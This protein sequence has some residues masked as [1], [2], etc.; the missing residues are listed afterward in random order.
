MRFSL[1]PA[2]ETREPNVVSELCFLDGDGAR[3]THFYATFASEA[4]F[5]VYGR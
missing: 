3:V 1:V 5:C 2:R 4:F